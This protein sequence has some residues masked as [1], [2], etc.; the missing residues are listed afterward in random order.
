MDPAKI[1]VVRLGAMGDIVHALPAVAT[2]KRSFPHAHLTWAVEPQWG[3]LLR[4]N[5]HVDRLLW[6]DLPGWRRRWWRLETCRK[7]LAACGDLRAA[8]FDLAIDFQ[9]LLK[10]ALVAAA[11]L[12]ER[13]A[14]FHR[15]LLREKAAGLFYSHHSRASSLHVVERN[16]DLAAEAG[17]ARRCV[18]F[19]LPDYPPEGDLPASDFVLASPVAGWKAKQW[20][21]AYYAQLTRLLGERLGWPLVIN[22]APG[23]RSD[24]EPILR[25][26]PEKFCRLHLSSVEGLI[27]ATR[28]ARAVVGIDS[29]P[30]HLAAAM[31]KPGVA[32]F[33]PTDPARNGPYGE[34]FLTLRSPGAITS[35]KRSSAISASMRALGPDQVFQ[36]LQ[37]QIE[38]CSVA[39]PLP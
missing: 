38:R 10:S 6:L 31:G 12:P 8:R 4:G 7:I 23:E 13:I 5:P 16:L 34:T 35:Y 2:L 19:P 33:G 18:E 36:A 9:G 27:A 30:L 25:E 15:S 28:R 26:A 20:P 21:P 3:A 22:F 32:L 29:G 1:L 11:A 14:G 39:A 17:A 37:R 24:A